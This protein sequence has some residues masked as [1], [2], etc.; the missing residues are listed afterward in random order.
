MNKY[1][2]GA[3]ILTLS[4]IFSIALISSAL[5]QNSTDQFDNLSYPIKELGNCADKDNCKSYCEKA[6]NLSACLSFAEKNGL[7]S[8]EEINVAKKFQKA[9]GKGPGGCVGK[10]SCEEYCNDISRINEC[11]AF[12]EK[13]NLL[14]AN[15][16]AEAKKVKAAIDKGINPPAC[17]NKKDC[18][19]Y[20]SDSSHMEECVNFA[21]AAGFMTEKEIQESKQVLNAIKKGANPPPCKGKDACDAYCSQP[22]N[23][24]KCMKFAI[25]A[26]FMS[27]GEKQDAE[28]F[29][30]AV[31]KGAKAPACKNKKDCDVYCAMEE[32]FEE[33]TNFAV[34]AG[35]MTEEDAQMAKKTGG[36]GPGG[37][38]NREEC[39]AFCGNP[40]NQETC[41][42]FGV[43][44]G[45]IPQEDLK[46]IEEGKQQFQNTLNQAGPEVSDC[47]KSAVGQEVLEKL[48]DGTFMPP[49][50]LG[51][52][53]RQCFE[54][55][56]PQGPQKSQDGK[57]GN[58]E[59]DVQPTKGQF[60]GGTQGMGIEGVQQ[61]EIPENIKNIIEEQKKSMMP[62]TNGIPNCSSAE[63]CKKL[64]QEQMTLPPQ[65]PQGSGQPGNFGNQLN[66]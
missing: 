25:E 7:M 1:F 8:Q 11:L 49:K 58:I 54:K 38:T 21:E 31:K 27:E 44:N 43:D 63:E 26:G 62:G 56:M 57:S 3:S 52:K 13:N 33:C 45:A 14:P 41:F 12:A 23:M 28:K 50:D 22:D 15:E 2:L 16:L 17:K 60:E 42:Q 48:S 55:N 47:L 46:K 39:E 6:E 9:G 61:G 32:H 5:A 36:K 20:C 51:E 4:L 37:C 18:D 35:Y 40:D 65:M 29:L 64:F 53:M 24:E 34:A 19:A 59:P 30:S 10:D 66:Q